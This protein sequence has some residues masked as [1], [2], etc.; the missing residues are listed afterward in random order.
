MGKQPLSNLATIHYG[1]S[2]KEVQVHHSPYPIF[3][4]GGQIGF[5]SRP[6]FEAPAITVGRKGTL[7]NPL[8]SEQPFWT[9]DTAYAVIPKPN[10]DAK[11]L[12]YQ[13]CNYD[14]ESLNEAT[15]VPSVSRDY[16]YRIKIFTVPLPEQRKIARILTTL[17]S[18]IT[19]TEQLI[20]KYEAIKQ[21]LMADLFTRGVGEDGRLRPS[22]S[23]APEL[24]WESELGWLP[25]GWEVK[26]LDDVIRI[27]DC[28]HYTPNFTDDSGIPFVRPR[29][30][31][32]EGLD[33]S[34]I[35]Y[36][37]EED[38][39]L[40]TDKHEPR[41]GDIVFS[42]NA[43]FGVP[44]YVESD[45]RFAIGQDVV[46][47]VETNTSS[48]FVYYTLLTDIIKRQIVQVSTGSTFG[49]INL[50][51]IRKFLVP[52]PKSNEQLMISEKL[53]AIDKNIDQEKEV[54][55]KLQLQKHGL[56]QDLLTGRV[57]VTID[58]E[59]TTDGEFNG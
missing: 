53:K 20:A 23:E 50:G 56:M 12:Y 42:R 9:I 58:E 25:R 17:D 28:K 22:V 59:G 39:Q 41:K 48:R 33:F 57:R 1:K 34:D 7:G 49:R 5:A 30:V 19:R 37:T 35:D 26:E 16:L 54:L 46:I 36:V 45:I 21:G 38:Y 14:L 40:L 43:S 4:T 3:G 2:Q 6:L 11:W 47:M 27:I 44:C 24:Y 13:L 31:K 8:Y 15:G 18:A 10:T 51:F 52:V 32:L 55:A 29:N